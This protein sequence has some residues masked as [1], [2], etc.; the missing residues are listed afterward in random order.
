MWS[1]GNSSASKD[2]IFNELELL[3]RGGGIGRASDGGSNSGNMVILREG[4]PHIT[5]FPPSP[6]PPKPSPRSSFGFNSLKVSSFD[7]I[8]RELVASDW[9]WSRGKSSAS[10]DEIFSDLELL[11][12]GGGIGRA[13]DG[14]SN[15]G[16]VVMWVSIF[17]RLCR[18]ISA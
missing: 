14:G 17:R 1:R 5:T 9:M 3:D 11:D 12:R 15:S 6:A 4:K 13:G 16:N 18:R 2:E 10:K 7:L 8:D